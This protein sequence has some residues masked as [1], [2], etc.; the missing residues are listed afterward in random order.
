MKHYKETIAIKVTNNTPVLQSVELFGSPQ[1]NFNNSFLKNNSFSYD[2]STET[3]ATNNLEFQ[4]SLT[5]PIITFSTLV[6]SVADIPPLLNTLGYGTFI[7]IG[8]II[9]VSKPKIDLTDSEIRVV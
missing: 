9:Y 4:L 5:S 1:S 3:F 2:L 6:F 7:A 8:N